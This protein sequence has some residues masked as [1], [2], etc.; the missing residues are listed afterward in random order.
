M[1]GEQKAKLIF[2]W[3]HPGSILSEPTLAVSPEAG[4]AT[5]PLR[6]RQR[7]TGCCFLVAIPA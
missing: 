1:L 5:M 7:F 2:A 6:C 3:T 4:L